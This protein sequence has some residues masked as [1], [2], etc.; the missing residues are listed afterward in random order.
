LIFSLGYFF[1]IKAKEIPCFYQAFLTEKRRSDDAEWQMGNLS[2][3]D[4]FIGWV[5]AFST[6]RFRPNGLKERGT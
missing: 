4:I 3:V 2:E 1:C 6:N 5:D